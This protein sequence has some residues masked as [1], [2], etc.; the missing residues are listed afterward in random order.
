M[1][2]HQKMMVDQEREARG[3]HAKWKWPG[4]LSD[5]CK[6]LS[7]AEDISEEEKETMRTKD[8]SDARS[9]H[10]FETCMCSS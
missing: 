1:I 3:T 10:Q 7:M 8:P 9:A 6:A 2:E 5:S 4:Q